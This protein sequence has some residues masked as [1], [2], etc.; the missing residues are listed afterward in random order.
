VQVLIS[1]APLLVHYIVPAGRKDFN[2]NH[3]SLQLLEHEEIR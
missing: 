2:E 3:R 1:S